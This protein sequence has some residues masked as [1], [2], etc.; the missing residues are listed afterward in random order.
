[1][2]FTTRIDWVEELPHIRSLGGMGY[3]MA[4]VG[5]VYGVSRQR[6]KQVVDRY[7]PEWFDSFGNAVNRKVAAEYYQKKWGQKLDTD[8]YRTQLIKFRA[9]KSNAQRVGYSWDISF[10]DVYFPTHCPILGIELDYYAESTVEGSPSFD[11]INSNL[12]YVKDNVQVIS[13]RANRI[14]N[15]GTA[16]EHR[17]IADYLDKLFMDSIESQ[18]TD[19]I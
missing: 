4:K 16:E 10:G 18:A 7:L 14:K 8:L 15:N 11:R 12:G 19:M 5:L 13:W 3:T 17:K 2:A 1:M 9:K 6:I